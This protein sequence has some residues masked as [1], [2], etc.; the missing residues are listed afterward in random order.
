MPKKLAIESEQCKPK[1]TRGIV[2]NRSGLAAIVGVSL[3]TIDAWIQQGMPYL[4]RADRDK[5]REWQFDTAAAIDWIR[6][7]KR[8]PMDW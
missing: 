7:N 8:Y 2:V 5:G 6:Q 3:P 1:G 4:R